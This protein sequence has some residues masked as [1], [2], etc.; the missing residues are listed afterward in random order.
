[1]DKP[2]V[3]RACDGPSCD[4]KIVFDP[5]KPDLHELKHWIMIGMTK[6]VENP[7]QPPAAQGVM[8]HAC[9]TT[10]AINILNLDTAM[11]TEEKS[12]DKVNLDRLRQAANAGEELPSK[13]VPKVQPIH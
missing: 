9:R 6:V 1:M 7:G 11:P 5:Q 4:S 2:L 10:C 8:K 12:E 3:S 13:S